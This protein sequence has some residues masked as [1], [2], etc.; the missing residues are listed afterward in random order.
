M[1]YKIIFIF[2]F[3]L[4]SFSLLFSQTI[5]DKKYNLSS[6][7]V[8]Y[9]INGGGVLT[10]DVNLSINGK[11]ILRFR[12]W[13]RVELLEEEVEEI[14]SGVLN[15]IENRNQCIKREYKQEF[16]VDFKNKKILER[17]VSKETL[18][19]KPT[20]G[21]VK[22]GQMTIAGVVCDIWKG[23]G[24][25]VCIYKKVPLLTEYHLLDMYY[26]K[27]AIDVKLDIKASSEKCTIPNF[28]LQKF[29]LFKTQIKLKNRQL[30]E[31]FL[32]VLKSVS[33]EMY[34]YLKESNTSEDN[35]TKKQKKVWLEK[36]GESTFKKQ[37]VLLPKMLLEMQKRRECLEKAE[38]W[39]DA[40]VCL[41]STS[42]L[43]MHFTK[44]RE[45]SISSWKEGDRDEIL[46]LLDTKILMMKSHMP[47][48]RS[49]KNLSDLA[50]CIK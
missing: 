5:A 34:A 26:Q 27:K 12:D 42:T 35:L 23:K 16:N 4:F 11:S 10:Q 31:P 18:N 28:P 3:L 37:K 7:M 49:S 45:H 38:N 25:T 17:P 9:T 24:I 19:Y 43:K 22:G 13:G 39:I 29:S 30:S 14:T 15:N 46:D 44:K 21:L 40:N 48:I 6:G 20:D 33:L 2:I 32:E 41:E 47:C 50:S 1:S 36:I 8:T